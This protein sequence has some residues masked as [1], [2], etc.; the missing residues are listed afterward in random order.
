[1]SV[2]GNYI[3]DIE[4]SSLNTIQITIGLVNELHMCQEYMKTLIPILVTVEGI[5]NFYYIKDTHLSP[6]AI[7]IFSL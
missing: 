1:M 6:T 4:G 2:V 5:C 7:H 3:L